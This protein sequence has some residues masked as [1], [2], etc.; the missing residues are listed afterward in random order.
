MTT[1][2]AHQTRKLIRDS[3]QHL[4]A[5]DAPRAAEVAAAALRQSPSDI[6]ARLAHA[7]ALLQTGD[8]DE[9]L[10]TLD[11]AHLYAHAEHSGGSPFSPKPG[12]EVPRIPAGS[13]SSS[14]H[15][16]ASLVLRAAALARLHQ[17]DAA[18]SAL[19][20]ALVLNPLHRAAVLALAAIELRQQQPDRAIAVLSR[21]HRATPHDR[22]AAEL[23]AEA[24]ESAGDLAGALALFATLGRSPAAMAHVTIDRAAEALH[25]ARLCRAAGSTRDALDIFAHLLTILPDDAPLALEAAALATATGEDRLAV[26]WLTAAIHARPDFAPLRR[27]LAEQHMAAG[28][29]PAAAR[30]W[31]HLTRLADPEPI[32]FAGLLVCSLCANRIGFADRVRRQLTDRLSADARRDLV[33][34][35]WRLA[36]PGRLQLELLRGPAS[37][38]HD[39]LSLLLREAS[40][41]FD[42]QL[43]TR[44][45]A[46]LHYHAAVCH[47][48]L[49][50][51]DS[52]GRALDSALALNPR[53]IAAARRRARLLLAQ[54]DLPA[55]AA[56]LDAARAGKPHSTEL[57]D[58]QLTTEILTGNLAA[59]IDQLRSA[60]LDR[61]HKSAIASAIADELTALNPTAAHQW[62]RTVAT[63]LGLRTAPM[64]HAA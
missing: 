59:A 41:T 26:A 12:D 50:D 2:L 19:R 14:R 32:A 25:I 33:A 51:E 30:L 34:Q 43:A 47:E 5:G 60:P 17:P 53:Y 55:A 40:T 27:A 57:L 42:H 61:D 16:L 22:R 64:S 3:Q 31:F 44:N 62:R 45:H 21:Y 11:A 1:D 18:R 8:A 49:G 52:A 20:E 6:A 46:D 48:S 58:L 13:P 23:L 28:R 63:D 10:R 36:M 35:M 38:S 56:L 29:F 7:E 15:T 54:H 39:T 4:A 24:C 37:H 9:A